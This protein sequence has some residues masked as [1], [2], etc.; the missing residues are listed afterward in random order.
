MKARNTVGSVKAFRLV[1]R[2]AK[3]NS[4]Q[5]AMKANTAAA[6]MP[7][8]A[9]GTATRPER[10]PAGAA[11]DQRRLLERARHLRK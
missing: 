3:K 4:V 10:A 6:T 9:S 1:R 8:A 2:R 11:V 5:Q 7:G